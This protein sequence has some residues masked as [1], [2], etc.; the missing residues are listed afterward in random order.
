MSEHRPTPQGP[1]P[2]TP[3]P[4][5]RILL[6]RLIQTRQ[7]MGLSIEQLAHKLELT[8]AQVTAFE[9][10]NQPL[11]FIDVRNW[12]LALGMPFTHFTQT[13]DDELRAKL[14][15]E[16]EELEQAPEVHPDPKPSKYTRADPLPH[17]IPTI[18]VL[19]FPIGQPPE[20]RTIPNHLESMQ[21]LVGGLITTFETGID[22]TIGV[23]ND[24]ALL[25]SMPL[26]RSVPATGAHIF[27]PFF[28]A[29][30]APPG[31]RSIAP[32]EL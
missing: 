11:G 27:G 18:Q 8:P 17:Q 20:I 16:L 31:F 2:F 15:E 21:E 23:A 1:T 25:E 7:D 24:E 4:A 19:F 28:V 5:Y 32:H 12:L 6:E 3:T 14:D 10:G 29:G 9:S 30:D 26:N 22:G 13:L